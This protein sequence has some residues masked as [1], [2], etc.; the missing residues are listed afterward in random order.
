MISNIIHE[1]AHSVPRLFVILAK[2]TI[3]LLA[4]TAAT[5][6]LRNRSAAL[7]HFLHSA[8]MTSLLLLPLAALLLP[9]LR[10]AVLP[11]TKGRVQNRPAVTTESNAPFSRRVETKPTDRRD[12]TRL[13][14]KVTMP[15]LRLPEDSAEDLAKTVTAASPMAPT[16]NG[17]AELNWRGI[18]VLLWLMGSAFFFLRMLWMS[19]RLHAL[20][21]R[22]V[23]V[24]AITLASRLRWLCRDLGIHR[25]V[26]LLASSELDVPIAAG[27]LS[28]KII[29]SPQS[30]EWC[31]TRRRAVLCHELAHVK[32]LDAL[33]QLIAG[34]A[35][36]LYWFHPLV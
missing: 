36:A 32:R 12:A 27:V 20:V 18:L 24:E 26:V 15:S 2:V 29:L 30:S 3:L 11:A 9:S 4:T 16:M 22:A 35:S 23:P 25:E 6:L 1:L 28:P 34:A 10:L 13:A 17:L 14:Q 31:E 5:Q 7:R 33:T 21:R 8:V 19:L